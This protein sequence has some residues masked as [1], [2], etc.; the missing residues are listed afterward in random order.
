MQHP[1]I[2]GSRGLVALMLII[3][4][5]TVAIAEPPPPETGRSPLAPPP[6]GA[7]TWLPAPPVEAQSQMPN[8]LV[9]GN[10]DDPAYPFYWRYPNHFVA[11]GWIR[12]WIHLTVLPEYD[13]ARSQR[14]YYDGGHAQVYFKWGHTYEAG[15]Y[16]VV[17]GLTPCTPYRFTMWARNHSL[18]GVLPHARIGLDPEGTQLTPSD[19]DCAVKTGLPPKTVWSREQTALFTWE[20]L[21]VE[22]EPLG[23]RLTAI[24]YAHPEPPN[25]GR[26]YYFDTIWDAGR[27]ITGTYP[28]GRMPEPLSWT[29]SGFITNVTTATVLNTLV[30]EWDTPAPAS[31]QVW[32][33][34]VSPTTPISFTGAYTVYLPLVMKA[35]QYAYATALD[36][37]PVT[38]HR[39]V[40]GGLQNG[41]IVRFVVLSRRASG[42]ACVTEVSEP[43]EVVISGIPPLSHVYLPVVSREDSNP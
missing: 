10:F 14:P 4:I 39:A 12:W 29:P 25:D 35:P 6:M 7:M 19:D 33:N 31:T 11:G 24:L 17:T 15:I 36:V 28:G 1:L 32:Y 43:M 5:A 37:T 20:E 41:Q 42:G 9:N 2:T 18:D 8:L 13:D 34:I 22:A 21:S 3:A 23:T 26:T 38:H 30:I 27:L 40:I 16:Q